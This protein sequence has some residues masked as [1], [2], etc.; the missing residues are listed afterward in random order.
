M[1]TLAQRFRLEYHTLSRQYLVNT[2]NS[3]ERRGFTTLGTA[4]EF[5]GQV[6]DFPLLDQSLLL[7]ADGRY[8]GALQVRLDLEALPAPFATVCLS[9][10]G[11][12]SEQRMVHM[13][14]LIRRLA[15][16]QGLTPALLLFGLLLVLLVLLAWA[17]TAA[18]QFE[19]LYFWLLPV[20]ALGLAALAA[21]IVYN[22][23]GLLRLCH[24]QVPG[25]RLTLRLAVIFAVLA[26][27]P[28]AMVYGFSLHVLQRSI[29]AGS[30]CA[31]IAAL[32]DALEL[33]RT[34][35]DLRMRAVLRQTTRIATSIAESEG[36]QIGRRLDELLDIGEAD[37][38]T[39]FDDSG[40]I[41]AT[42]TADPSIILP[43]SPPDTVLLQVQQGRNYVSL[44]PGR[45]DA[46]FHI[47]V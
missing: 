37:E 46:S 23:V 25:A 29:V 43:N 1:Y 17:S 12:A 42:A 3:G 14:A 15:R 24:R 18:V 30:T 13:A 11:L 26:I 7:P 40:R 35:L 9:V 19:R 47:R 8:E 20:S 36:E 45:G 44:E 39:L 5:M 38:L 10:R 21:L 41:V 28:V 4:L 27:V 2:L 31:S 34:A 22:L 16:G 32:E 6:H 33:S